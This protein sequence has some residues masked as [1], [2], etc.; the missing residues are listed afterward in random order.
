MSLGMALIIKQQND[1]LSL[2]FRSKV[3][4]SSTFECAEFRFELENVV[5]NAIFK[6]ED[7]K[8]K[9]VPVLN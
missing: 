1:Q 2:S 4:D 8:E 5:F 9:V 6:G 3:D 7:G